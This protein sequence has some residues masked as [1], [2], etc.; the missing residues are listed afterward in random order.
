M[1]LV[2]DLVLR[3]KAVG[4]VITARYKGEHIGVQSPTTGSRGAEQSPQAV[5][6]PVMD[7]RLHNI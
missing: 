3:S 5:P 1:M 7:E 4:V 6:C 2:P